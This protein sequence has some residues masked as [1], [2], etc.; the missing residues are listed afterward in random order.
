MLRSPNFAIC[1]SVV[2]AGG[3]PSPGPSRALS[4]RATADGGT[5]APASRIDEIAG[6]VE[7]KFYSA[8]RLNEVGWSAAVTRARHE[9]AGAPTTEERTTIVSKLIAEL[10]TSHTGYYPRTDPL[11]WQ[12]A[13]IFEP[14]LEQACPKELMPGFPIVREDIGVFWKQVEGKWFVRGVFV[15]SPADKAGLKLG[16]C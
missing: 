8:E 1:M 15:S 4:Q 9:F 5:A 16:D 14:Y 13:S 11:Y 10:K 12:W 7:Q 2:F 3:A 6:I